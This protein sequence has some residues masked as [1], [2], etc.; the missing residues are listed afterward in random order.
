MRVIFSA[1]SALTLLTIT[2]CA[3]TD[4]P[5]GV[6]RGITF[7]ATPLYPN[8]YEVTAG[9]T[10]KFDAPVLKDA[11]MKKAAQLASGRK[12]KTSELTV[13][14]TE[15]IPY[16]LYPTLPMQGRSV[17]GTMSLLQ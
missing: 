8:G 6:P 13:H 12:Y 5:P 10:R 2:G 4:M 15:V 17:T 14:D 9:G 1:L 3:T 11:W 16:S 7:S